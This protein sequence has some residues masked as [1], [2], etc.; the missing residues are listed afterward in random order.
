MNALIRPIIPFDAKNNENNSAKENN[1]IL[2]SNSKESVNLRISLLYTLEG[3]TSLMKV[4]ICACRFFREINGKL[5]IRVNRQSREG[6]MAM[7]KL[8]EMADALSVNPCVL[9]R[10]NV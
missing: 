8:Y 6:G 9:D 4:W 10:K 2:L 1:P 7:M 5:G 3:T